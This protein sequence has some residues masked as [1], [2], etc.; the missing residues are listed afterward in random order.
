M[1]TF[2]KL[3]VADMAR[4]VGFYT[5]LGFSIA[6][7]DDVF[8]QLRLGEAELWLVRTPPGRGLEGAR[9]LGVLVCFRADTPGVD[10]LA[11]K[12][13]ALGAP[14]AGP[15][16]QPWHTREIIVTDPDG[17]RVNFLQSSW[18]DA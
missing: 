7:Q 16:D 18:G 11:E 17:Y 12:A 9:G 15:V 3:L 13:R 10:S 14:V 1:S 2:A 6:H 5:A 8:T 4:S